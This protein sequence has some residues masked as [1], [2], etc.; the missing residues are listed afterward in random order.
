MTELCFADECFDLIWSEGA[1]YSMGFAAGF[2]EW[3]RFLRPGGCLAVTEL[4]WLSDSAPESARAFWKQHYPAMTDTRDNLAAI[5]RAGYEPIESFSL[6]ESDWW[7]HFYS[8]LA[9]EI[10]SVEREY[11]QKEP[12]EG[13]GAGRAVIDMMNREM[14]V[15]REDPDAYSYV[16]YIARK[17]C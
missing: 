4:T 1:I 17:P 11:A 7:D 2:E 10:E 5:E 9:A 3:K 13:L 14:E 15:L 8:G 16:F 6:P 12:G